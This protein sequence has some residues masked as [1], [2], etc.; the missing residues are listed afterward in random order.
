MKISV[1]TVVFNRVETILQSVMSIQSQSWTDV[2][3]VVVDGASTD[4]TLVVLRD[5]LTA[6]AVFVSE[7]DKGIY[8]ALNKGYA[9]ATGDIVGVMHSDDFYANESVLEMIA[10]AF[11]DSTVDAVYGDLD[12]VSNDDLT[13]VVRHWESG[14]YSSAKLG[15]GWMPP[16]PTLYLRRSVIERLGLYDTRFDISADY[17]LILRYFVTGKLKSVYIPQVLVKMRL[18]G[19]SNRSLSDIWNKSKEDYIALRR[20]GVGGVT[21]L[22]LKNFRKV[23]QFF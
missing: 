13:H 4:G 21:S 7:P 10:E 23:K 17:E 1:V 12:Y 5:L 22:A 18:G 19:V 8:D 9:L 6:N 16:H 11:E 20:H 3:H 15:R 2:E 14:E